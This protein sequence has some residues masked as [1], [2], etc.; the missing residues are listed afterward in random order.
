MQV[1]ENKQHFLFDCPLYEQLGEKHDFLFGLDHGSI[2]L[3][4]ERNAAQLSSVAQD[5]HLC[6]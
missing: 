5:I 4:F 3:P 6:L 1:V 2:R